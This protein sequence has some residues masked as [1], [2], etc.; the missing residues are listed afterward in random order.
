[1]LAIVKP[2]VY[3]MVKIDPL[4]KENDSVVA[5]CPSGSKDSICSTQLKPSDS[6]G[7]AWSVLKGAV[8]DENNDVS[9]KEKEATKLLKDHDTGHVLQRIC[10]ENGVIHCFD[11]RNYVIVYGEDNNNALI[12]KA[13]ES[14]MR[15]LVADEKYSEDLKKQRGKERGN[16]LKQLNIN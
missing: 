6:V 14:M 2:N 16:L 3:A 5:K 8:V 10:K 7:Y 15:Q 11:G 9:I 4:K 12:D 13:E 1:M